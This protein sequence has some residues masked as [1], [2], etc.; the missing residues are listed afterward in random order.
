MRVFH[1]KPSYGL[2]NRLRTISSSLALT[3]KYGM[4]LRVYW[5][6][7]P[8]C[9]VKWS[10]ILE[11]PREFEVVDV[12]PA[13]DDY[14]NVLFS[15][16]NPCFFF[17]SQIKELLNSCASCDCTDVAHENFKP[18][19]GKYDY[20]W[21]KPSA[22]VQAVV[23][24]QKKLFSKKTIGVHIRRTDNSVAIFSSPT[25][26]YI[27]LLNA[28][29]EKD[30]EVGFF[31]ACDDDKEKAAIEDAFPGRVVTCANVAGR[32]APGGIKDAIVDLLLLAECSKIYGSFWSS[33]SA[34]ASKIGK[35]ELV[36]V[37]SGFIAVSFIVIVEQS[38]YSLRRCMN[39]L[40]KQWL[41]RVE[42][43]CV[44]DDAGKVGEFTDRDDRVKIAGTV[45]EA[46]KIAKGK[47]SVTMNSN[48]VAEYEMAKLLFFAAEKQNLDL[49]F[50]R[51]FR[52]FGFSLDSELVF[53]LNAFVESS[54]CWRR[55]HNSAMPVFLAKWLLNHDCCKVLNAMNW[56][57]KTELLRSRGELP[58]TGWDV[59]E[60]VRAGFYAK[61]LGARPVWSGNRRELSDLLAR[62]GRGFARKFIIFIIVKMQEVRRWCLRKMKNR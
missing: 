39:S 6:D 48:E 22:D 61:N 35:N 1:V 25:D 60:P 57:A 19:F 10:E 14:D 16:E 8:D 51:G 40:L 37:D 53:R 49:L 38:V 9:H 31:L 20:G 28:E 12:D 32:F 24:A 5:F 45:S 59:G 47:Y 54:Y 27:S 33:F 34:E 26:L 17:R 52:Y 43:I 7:T 41:F 2:A 46:L 50:F 11:Y 56:F 29:V 3:R 62:A 55:M 15:T 44:C 18:F 4:R 21:L 30:P 13:A 42:I 36:I 58:F 23:N